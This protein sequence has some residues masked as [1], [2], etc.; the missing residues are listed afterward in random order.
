MAVR[1]HDRHNLAQKT[2]VLYE[3]GLYCNIDLTLVEFSNLGEFWKKMGSSFLI[4]SNIA[5]LYIWLLIS[6][7]AVKRSFSVYNN[8]LEDD[9]QNL[10]ENSLKI[11]NIFYFNQRK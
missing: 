3:W 4:L 6:S 1:P 5:L 11:L 10:N 2:D 8:L 9:R 7:C